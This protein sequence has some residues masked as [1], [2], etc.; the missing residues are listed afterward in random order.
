ME[1]LST[2]E[3]EVLTLTA[4]DCLSAKEIGEKLFISPVTAQNH[5]KNIKAKLNLQKVTELCRH[6]YTN[7]MAAFLLLIFLPNALQPNNGMMR[8]RRARRTRQETEFILH[9]S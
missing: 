4:R 7:V 5:I 8:A 1:V 2:R 3:M 6:Y 9:E